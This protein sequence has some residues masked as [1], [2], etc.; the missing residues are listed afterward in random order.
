MVKNKIKTE[1]L[2]EARKPLGIYIERIDDATDNFGESYGYWYEPHLFRAEIE[3]C[4]YKEYGY[5]HQYS[6]CTGIEGKIAPKNS[7][8]DLGYERLRICSKECHGKTV[9]YSIAATSWEIE[10]KLR[11]V[12]AFLG[13]KF[14]LNSKERGDLEE[15]IQTLKEYQKICENK[16]DRLTPEL[17]EK[18]EVQWI[19]LVMHLKKI[20][21]TGISTKYPRMAKELKEYFD[22]IKGKRE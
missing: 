9:G 2:K 10:D 18:Y 19:Y 12:Q 15:N 13:R 1:E 6:K 21:V 5:H 22:H 17:K 3:K 16:Y 20:A 8:G 14:N 7:P 4:S 11:S